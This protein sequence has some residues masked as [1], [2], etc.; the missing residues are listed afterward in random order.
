MKKRV[1]ALFLAA[2]LG[3]SVTACGTQEE[4]QEAHRV[5]VS[6]ILPETGDVIV[7]TTYIGTVEPKESITIY[8]MVDGNITQMSAAL[9]KEVKKGEALFTLD[10]TEANKAVTEAQEEYDVLK[11]AAEQAKKDAEQSEKDTE[12][13]KKNAATA[14]LELIKTNLTTVVNDL[15]DAK[16]D[17]N[18]AEDYL[19][20]FEKDSDGSTSMTSSERT[21]LRSDIEDAESKVKTAETAL[22]T[23]ETKLGEIEIAETKLSTIKTNINDTKEDIKDIKEALQDAKDRVKTSMSKSDREKLEKYLDKAKDK[24][25]DAKSSANKAKTNLPTTA[26]VKTTA[27]T[28]T[29]GSSANSSTTSA[30]GTSLTTT[31]TTAYEQQLLLAEKKLNEAKALLELYQVMAPIDGVVEAVYIDQNE[32]AFMDEPCLVISNKSNI[33]VTFQVPEAAALA[34]HVGDKVR[35]EKNGEMHDASITEVGI[36]ADVQTKLFTVKASLGAAAGFSTG[37]DVKVYAETQKATGT[38]LIPYDSLYFQGGDA[39]VYCVVEDEAVRRPVQVGLMNDVSAQILDGLESTDIV[40]S[41][42][43]SQLKDGA[44]VDLLFVIGNGSTVDVPQTDSDSSD[45][46]FDTPE[47][48]VEDEPVQI[49]DDSEPMDPDSVEEE[50]KW[51]LPDWQ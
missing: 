33:E 5:S 41:T 12:T 20:D 45:V 38:M 18:D 30:S 35:V 28:T 23:A 40:I 10:N 32:K 36:M 11:K 29:S 31:V 22:N 1:T 9:G 8:P 44:A 39:Y 24:V 3:L 37:T 17:V 34:L 26:T 43:T 46:P 13:A 48:E 27:S 6:G 4:L 21:K 50:N 14:T 2:L 42:W 16:A 15:D 47:V 49:T 51:V 19:K 25:D 7:T